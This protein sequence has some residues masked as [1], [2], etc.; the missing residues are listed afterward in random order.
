MTQSETSASTGRPASGTA[1]AALP[2]VAKIAQNTKNAIRMLTVGPPA[3]TTTF[4][5]HGIL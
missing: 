3:I 2:Y 5:H 1:S 4:F